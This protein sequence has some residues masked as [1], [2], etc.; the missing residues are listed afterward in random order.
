MAVR[1]A[2]R[3]SAV[4]GSPLSRASTS[5]I[6]SR[7]DATLWRR[8]PS[9]AVT[10]AV[11]SPWRVDVFHGV[12]RCLDPLPSNVAH[13]RGDGTGVDGEKLDGMASRL[14]GERRR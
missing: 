7:R 12:A 14:C 6:L 3:S 10:I 1:T 13:R 11:I 9:T 2:F 5:D 4:V 8:S